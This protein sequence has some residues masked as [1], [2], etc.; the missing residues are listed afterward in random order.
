M[1]NTPTFQGIKVE[2]LHYD[3]ILNCKH[4]IIVEIEICMMS[5]NQM[6]NCVFQLAMT[7]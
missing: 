4:I 1:Q 6:D 7:R 5:K 3:Q 2:K